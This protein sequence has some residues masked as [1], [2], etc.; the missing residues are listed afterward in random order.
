LSHL[1]EYRS[2]ALRQETKHRFADL[3]VE[4][5]RIRWASAFGSF[6]GETRQFE[7]YFVDVWSKERVTFDVAAQSYGMFELANRFPDVSEE[8]LLRE[9]LSWVINHV[10]QATDREMPVTRSPLSRHAG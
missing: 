1:L 8:P 9:L 3:I 4:I 6:N 10:K 2:G 5:F 7:P